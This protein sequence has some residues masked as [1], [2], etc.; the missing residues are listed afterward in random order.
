MPGPFLSA[1]LR[2]TSAGSPRGGLE[3]SLSLAADEPTALL[4][5]AQPRRARGRRAGRSR[6]SGEEDEFRTGVGRA[7]RADPGP[8]GH[9][10]VVGR[11]SVA[12]VVGRRWLSGNGGLLRK[13][14][15]EDVVCGVV[16]P[17]LVSTSSPEPPAPSLLSAVRL[18]VDPD[19]HRVA[20]GSDR[21][22]HLDTGSRAAH[23]WGSLRC[24]TPSPTRRPRTRA[25]VRSVAVSAETPG[26]ALSVSGPPM[27]TRRSGD[28]RPAAVSRRWRPRRP[29]ATWARAPSGRTPRSAWC[30]SGARA[31]STS[32]RTR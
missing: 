11:K 6:S 9:V 15:V 23:K 17:H 16:R 26:A 3:M 10:R 7:G 5:Q 19:R 20:P 21:N 12:P 30:R 22:A 32:R 18:S 8:E 29:S 14:H 13:V 28:P 31:G 1:P 2:V 27:D 4:S 24:L 25:R